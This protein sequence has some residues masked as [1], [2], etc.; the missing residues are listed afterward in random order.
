[1]TALNPWVPDTFVAPKRKTSIVDDLADVLAQMFQEDYRDS[2]AL[3]TAVDSDDVATTTGSYTGAQW[4]L[5]MLAKDFSG[6]HTRLGQTTDQ[7]VRAKLTF[8]LRR[9]GIDRGEI[10]A[11]KAEYKALEQKNS[12]S[13]PAASETGE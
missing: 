8:A 5:A 9:N 1:M 11:R 3:M 6:E 12:A 13:E 10:A 4:R 2:R 7:E